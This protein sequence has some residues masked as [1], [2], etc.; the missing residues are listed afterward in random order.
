MYP[1]S[2]LLTVASKLITKHL[3]QYCEG[4]TRNT[5]VNCFWTF[6]SAT[7]VLTK[8]KILNRWL[9]ISIASIF[10]LYI[11]HDL[12]QH[13]ISQLIRGITGAKYLVIKNDGGAY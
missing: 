10:P 13:S 3:K 8:F 1:L 12:L 4:I 5:G 11:P 2:Q 9:G 6:N 7:E